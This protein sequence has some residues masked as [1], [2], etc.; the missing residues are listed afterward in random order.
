MTMINGGEAVY[1]TLKANGIDTVF[2]LLGG[3][4]LEL[5]DA[6]LAGGEIAYV[7]ARDERAAGHMADAYARMTGGP[8]IVLGAP[9]TSRTTSLYP[10]TPIPAIRAKDAAPPITLINVEK[11]PRPLSG[12][13]Y[14]S[15]ASTSNVSS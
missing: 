12:S 2:G 5:Y 15:S 9:L 13:G 3:S 8:G 10:Q 1:R 7:G 14:T 11:V 4:M 6:M